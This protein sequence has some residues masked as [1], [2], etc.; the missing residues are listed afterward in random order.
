MRRATWVFGLV[1][2]GMAAV[3]AGCGR[4]DK[5]RAEHEAHAQ[6]KLGAAHQTDAANAAAAADADMVSAVSAAASAGLV[7]LK[8][9]MPRPPQVGQDLRLELALVQPPGLDIELMLVSFQP[10]DG[11][12]LQSEHTLE[13]HL[14]AVGA[15]QRMAVTLRPLQ[16]GL[17]SLGATVLVD[18]GSTSV[19]HSFSIPLIAVPAAQ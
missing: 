1:A 17:L 12:L 8:F 3:L 14:P 9:R 10:G 6:S 16:A 19:S 11:L 2:L 7:G 5:A 15:T 4:A 13:F 18:A